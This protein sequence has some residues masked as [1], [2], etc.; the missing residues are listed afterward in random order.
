[1]QITYSHGNVS[2]TVPLFAVIQSVFTL[3][4]VFLVFG[5]YFGVQ[6]VIGVL[7]I[8]SGVVVVIFSSGNEPSVE[9]A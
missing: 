7:T 4:F 8:I 9:N 2:I 1:M 3:S 5:K 6:K